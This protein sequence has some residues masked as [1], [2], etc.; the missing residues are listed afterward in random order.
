MLEKDVTKRPDINQLLGYVGIRLRVEK[1]QQERE[2]I[3]A[4]QQLESK[5]IEKCN[6]LASRV[7]QQSQVLEKLKKM[8]VQSH[9]EMEIIL[10][11]TL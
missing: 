8:Q 11:I 2:W 5:M 3:S 7:E 1:A 6:I 4:F 9:F 10:E